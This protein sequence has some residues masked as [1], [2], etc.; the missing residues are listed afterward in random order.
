MLQPALSEGEVTAHPTF[1]Q[2]ATF[3]AHLNKELEVIAFLE[4][5]SYNVVDSWPM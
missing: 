1:Q 3:V 5:E 2:D 4:E